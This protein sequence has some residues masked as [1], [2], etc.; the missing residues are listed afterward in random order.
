MRRFGSHRPLGSRIGMGFYSSRRR[1]GGAAASG[2]GMPVD[3][4]MQ[5]DAATSGMSDAT[6]DAMPDGAAAASEAGVPVD[7]AM[8][9]DAATSGTSA[10]VVDQDAARDDTTA[11]DGRASDNEGEWEAAMHT[12]TGTSGGHAYDDGTAP[13]GDDDDSPP[14]VPEYACTYDELAKHDEGVFERLLEVPLAVERGYVKVRVLGCP[15]SPRLTASSITATP[16][17]ERRT[18]ECSPAEGDMGSEVVVQDDPL[19]GPSP[20]FDFDP[21]SFDR[22]EPSLKEMRALV[23]RAVSGEARSCDRYD[24]QAPI[25]GCAAVLRP[26]KGLSRRKRIEGVTTCVASFD[27]DDVG[28]FTH[29]RCEVGRLGTTTLVVAGAPKI[30]LVVR[31]GS[32]DQMERRLQTARGVDE[33]SS[34]QWVDEQRIAIRPSVLDGWGVEFDLVSIG[35]GEALVTV[36]GF[37]YRTVVNTGPCLAFSCCWEARDAP[38]FPDG[39]RFY[40]PEDDEDDG[41]WLLTADA[42]A[43]R[44]S[45][46]LCARTLYADVVS[47]DGLRRVVGLV[48]ALKAKRLSL[49]ELRSMQFDVDKA[50]TYLVRAQQDDLVSTLL[51]RYIL[52]RFE[53]L[54]QRERP[55]KEMR[56]VREKLTKAKLAA[57]AWQDTYQ[58]RRRLRREYEVP[59]KLLHL[60]FDGGYGILPLL[61]TADRRIERLNVVQLKEFAGLMGSPLA[62]KFL[63]IGD[64]LMDAA[65]NDGAS[66][67][68]SFRLPRGVPGPEAVVDS[69]PLDHY[70]GLILPGA[71]GG[72]TN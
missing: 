51:R 7:K 72:S 12:G 25:E 47:H 55:A 71:S 64:A 19:P 42:F 40:D 58:N 65:F 28:T 29:T 44:T 70:V 14:D 18:W 6:I 26:G 56:A 43:F 52:L 50:C 67:S 23:E 20:D 4:A 16:A 39:Y 22:W 11:Y 36:P 48:V 31:P 21:D 33:T 27:H 17:L 69:V 60:M 54:F 68:F 30:F 49:P 38:E 9:N 66:R 2:A 1:F 35:P 5:N 59:R 53:E 57:N 37:V 46:E 45:G 32:A 24:G 41:P 15:I 63:R 10:A 34:S 13:E 8:Q 62:A 3:S 61:P